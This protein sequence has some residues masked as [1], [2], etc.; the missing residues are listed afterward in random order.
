METPFVYGKLALGA[1]FTDRKNETAHLKINFSSGINTIIISSRRWGKSSLV[2]KAAQEIKKENHKIKVVSIDLFNVRTEEEFYRN[3]AEQV[4]HNTTSKLT[5]IQSFVKTFFKQWIPKITFS[6]DHIQELS[7]GLDWEEVKKQPDEILDLP[8][9]IGA[10]KGWKIIVCF[11]EFQN[12]G[13]F[14]DNISFQKLLRAH[15]QRHPD[16]SYC[17]YGSKRHMLLN[18]FTSPSMPFYNFGDIL[19]LEKI[20]S[21][22]WEKFITKRFKDTGKEIAPE[23]SLRIATLVDNHPYYVQQLAQQCWLRCDKIL[24]DQIIDQALEGLVMQLGLLFQNMTETLSNTQVNYL[25]AMVNGETRFSTKE[26]I[27][28][29]DLGSSANVNRIKN[30][31]IVKE[32]IDML[33]GKAEFLDPLYKIWL[34]RYYFIGNY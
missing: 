20:G 28:E 31:L 24:T 8:Q 16:V 17:L 4:I 29:Y 14:S 12:I 11:D 9:K 3:L 15:W 34:K 6:P 2:A 5:E 33:N 7:L 19:F 23:Q 30:A 32:I 26:I 27:L 22:H 25:R 1:D 21:T 10:E 18:V 13:Y